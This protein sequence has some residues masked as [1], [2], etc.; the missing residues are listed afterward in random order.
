M[1]YDEQKSLLS[2]AKSI[3]EGCRP[4][5]FFKAVIGFRFQPFIQNE[6][7]YRVLDKLGIIYISGIKTGG[8]NK[9]IDE[10]P[11]LLEGHR[12]HVIPVTSI[13]YNKRLIYLND[14][15]PFLD[16]KLKLKSEEWSE[17]LSLSIKQSIKK[18]RPLVLI[19]HDW[20][21]GSMEK[22]GYWKPFV[23]F[24]DEVEGRAT[25]IKTHELV[26]KNL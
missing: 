20:Y 23:D 8:S 15:D 26:T 22:Y 7:T 11:R 2:N 13:S 25:F 17:V 18:N 3:L 10:L 21:I 4:C 9:K 16:E 14:S 12:F 24:L 5:G 1:K 19:L 6:D